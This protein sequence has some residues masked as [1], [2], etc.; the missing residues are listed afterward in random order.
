MFDR[1]HWVIW[2]I[3][4]SGL[5]TGRPQ[6]CVTMDTRVLSL[7]VQGFGHP[8]D[9]V[10]ARGVL[11]G[12][13]RRQGK[14]YFFFSSRRFGKAPASPASRIATLWDR[15]PEC[16]RLNVF[17]RDLVESSR[18]RLAPERPGVFASRRTLDKCRP[19][20]CSESGA[21]RLAAA[22]HTATPGGAIPP[23]QTCRL[24]QRRHLPSNFH[25][26]PGGDSLV[27]PP[28]RERS[29]SPRRFSANTQT[30]Q[31]RCRARFL[32]ARAPP[33]LNA[34]PRQPRMHCI[35]VPTPLT[36]GTVK[37]HQSH[38]SVCRG[39]KRGFTPVLSRFSPAVSLSETST[40]G[41]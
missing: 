11:R 27:S 34:S 7:N 40:A 16:Q 36:C 31:E 17:L 6:I 10:A 14:S 22:H 33:P 2:F 15:L 4:G 9:D 25:P 39:V 28:H 30:M 29:T 12:K 1:A 37:V 20:S 5:G 35:I 26:L 3:T 24:C 19:G 38:Y 32:T 21:H 23:H 41:R 8:V 18:N 13:R